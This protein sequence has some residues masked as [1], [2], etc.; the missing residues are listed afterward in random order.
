MWSSGTWA[1]DWLIA[2]ALFSDFLM[3][4]HQKPITMQRFYVI[5]GAQ[6][7]LCWVGKWK[8]HIEQKDST[9]FLGIFTGY[10]NFTILF[11]HLRQRAC[12]IH[13]S[14][15]RWQKMTGRV[16]DC[17]RGSDARRRRSAG[18]GGRRPPWGTGEAARISGCVSGV[19]QRVSRS[20]GKEKK[21][22]RE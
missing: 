19:S 20:N 5:R 10:L 3:V 1:I 17:L 9:T 12:K 15:R 14:V 16:C 4:L 8:V 6:Y 2:Y 21:R 22:R 18:K 7:S 13:N 11:W